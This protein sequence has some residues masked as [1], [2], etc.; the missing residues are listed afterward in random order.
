MLFVLFVASAAYWHWQVHRE[1]D[2]GQADAI[3]AFSFPSKNLLPVPDSPLGPNVPVPGWILHLGDKYRQSIEVC[4][5]E[6]GETAFRLTS[7]N[8]KTE[9]Y[10]SSGV[11]SVK[12][13]MKFAVEASFRKSDDFQGGAWLAVSVVKNSGAGDVVVEQYV[14]K[15]PAMNRRGGWIMA[16]HTF[17]LPKGTHSVRVSLRGKFKGAVSVK[18]IILECKSGT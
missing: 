1:M 10:L 2:I 11:I 7:A 9:M 3:A 12:D 8:P 17:E 5:G 15:E 16:K 13:S 18:N 4:R 14:V 6:D